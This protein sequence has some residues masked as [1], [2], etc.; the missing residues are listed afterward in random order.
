VTAVRVWSEAASVSRRAV[1][2]CVVLLLLCAGLAPAHSA[3][4]VRPPPIAT[5]HPPGCGIALPACAPAQRSDP[6]MLMAAPRGVP[7]IGPDHIATLDDAPAAPLSRTSISDTTPPGLPL[8]LTA[9][10]EGLFNLSAAWSSA[11]DDD[12]GV[13]YYVVG[14]GS[15]TTGTQQSD[16][17][18]WQAVLGTRFHANLALTAGVTVY[19][20]V[21]AVNGAGIAGT[22]TT[23]GPLLPAPAVYGAPTNSV[24]FTIAPDGLDASGNITHSWDLTRT[25]RIHGFLDRMLPILRD[26][27]G[28]P[29]TSITVTLRRN[30]KYTISAVFVP[31]TDEIQGGDTF[32]AQLLAHEFAHAWRNDRLL[33]S[34]AL[35]QFDPTFSG[36]EEAFAHAIGYEVLNLFVQRHPDF[37][38]GAR[39]F[40]SSMEWDYDF[41]NVPE[42]RNTDFWSDQGGML[43]SWTRYETAAAAIAKIERE[44]PGFYRAFNAAFFARLNAA[45]RL[46]MTNA[47]IT[48]LIAQVAPVIEGLPAGTWLSQQHVFASRIVTG[49]KV[50]SFVQRYPRDTAPHLT[51]LTT[52]AYE[53]FPN[54]SD[55][56]WQP[57][58]GPARAHRW[59]GAQGQSVLAGAGRTI[60]RSS[61]L[62]PTAAPP[63]YNGF[64][65][66]PLILTG[67][68]DTTAWPGGPASRYITDVNALALYT[69]T[70]SFAISG[71]SARGVVHDVHGAPLAG[72]NGVWGGILGAVSGTVTLSHAHSADVVTTT[73]INGAFHAEPAW[74]GVANT[75][76]QTIDSLPGTVHITF[77]DLQGRRYVG[78]RSIG[79]GSV[80]GNQAWLFALGRNGV[81]TRAGDGNSRQHFLPRVIR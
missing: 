79:A 52:Y 50:W 1:C 44:Y 39:A 59:N 7:W 29:A 31:D 78:Q 57:A 45:P 13:A 21:Y 66:S 46:T 20:S 72:A 58:T 76:T 77:T 3:A 40:G 23:I 12:S 6:P 70:H 61:V 25:A 37:N 15:G 41:Q 16:V 32:P 42:L 62:S 34:G 24:T 71:Q 47:V 30:L 38:L 5:P 36:Y 51:F 22:A 10:S 69:L 64:G 74:A 73:L 54:G 35:W 8:S 53:T 75:S 55:W 19:V 67:Q 81:L 14:V 48:D 80:W 2:V 49:P 27:Y 68:T 4:G 33:S 43:L 56:F 60:T 63:V 18:Y 11:R 65:A 28:P 17:R 26:V 9:R